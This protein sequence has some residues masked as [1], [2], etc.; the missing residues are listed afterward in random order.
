MGPYWFMKLTNPSNAR[1]RKGNMIFEPSSGGMGIRLNTKSSALTNATPITTRARVP[2]WNVGI[3][4]KMAQTASMSRF[5]AG[6][7]EGHD[8]GSEYSAPQLGEHHRGGLPPTETGHQEHQATEQVQV[9]EG[10]ERY[11]S[12]PV[13]GV[14]SQPVG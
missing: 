9:R 2:P 8:H 13:S 14:V 3:R 7:G 10:I 12:L 6:P 4:I 1:G 5:E 11:P